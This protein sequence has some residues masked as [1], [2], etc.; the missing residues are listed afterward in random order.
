MLK[1][2]IEDAQQSR[3]VTLEEILRAQEKN[4][5]IQAQ[6]SKEVQPSSDARMHCRRLVLRWFENHSMIYLKKQFLSDGERGL[7]LA[8]NELK[9]VI[10]L[11]MIGDAWDEDK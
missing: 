2:E 11:G 6:P 9:N 5:Q 4:T 8:T 1:V 3:K 7:D 10:F